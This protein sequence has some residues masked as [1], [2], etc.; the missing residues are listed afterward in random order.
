MKEHSKHVTGWVDKENN[1]ADR[2]AYIQTTQSLLADPQC[3]CILTILRNH[4]ES[5]AA[6]YK[7]KKTNSHIMQ[8]MQ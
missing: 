1:L 5:L 2:P 7:L 4:T 6:A 3:I 8:I